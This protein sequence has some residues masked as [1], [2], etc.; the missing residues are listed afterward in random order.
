VKEGERAAT[1]SVAIGE[2]KKTISI[3]RRRPRGKG[4]NRGKS[5]RFSKGALVRDQ[6]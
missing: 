4:T 1:R 2:G 3:Y 5:K 6:A